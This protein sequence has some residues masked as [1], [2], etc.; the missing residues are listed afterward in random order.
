VGPLTIPENSFATPK[1]AASA[2]QCQSVT[3]KCDL[4]T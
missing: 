4:D 1:M 2:V 3:V